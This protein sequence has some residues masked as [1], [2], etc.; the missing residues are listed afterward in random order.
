[1]KE[2]IKTEQ[3]ETSGVSV[4]TKNVASKTT[5]IGNAEQTA[6]MLK[7]QRKS[8]DGTPRAT[9]VLKAN[10]KQREGTRMLE[11]AD[12]TLQQLD[13]TITD[14]Y[15]QFRRTTGLSEID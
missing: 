5:E 7:D 8:L 15:A 6:K 12:K 14:S 4:I 10:L 2:K 13:G 9:I 3:D 11:L 1:M